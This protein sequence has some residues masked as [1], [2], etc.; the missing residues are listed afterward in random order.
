M[1]INMYDIHHAL[2]STYLGGLSDFLSNYFPF[3]LF[4][5]L[6]SSE[7]SRTLANVKHLSEERLYTVQE[8][9]SSS[10]NSA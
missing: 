6:D 5:V 9:T 2:E 3:V 8:L 1:S 4:I 10:A 7:Q